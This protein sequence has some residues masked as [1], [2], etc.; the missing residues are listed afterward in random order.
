MLREPTALRSP[1]LLAICP[2]EILRVFFSHIFSIYDT[3][4]VLVMVCPNIC[5]IIHL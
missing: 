3:M 2:R 4:T 1:L 5:V